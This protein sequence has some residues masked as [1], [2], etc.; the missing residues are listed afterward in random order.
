MTGN[1]FRCGYVQNHETCSEE[2]SNTYFS[3]A[4]C[5]EHRAILARNLSDLK[6]STARQSANHHELSDFPG[7]CYFA[8]MPDASVKIG[9]S[10][11][12]ELLG[13]RFKNISK[14]AGSHVIPL[15]VIRGGF[16]AEA[17]MHHRFQEDRIWEESERFRYTPAMAEF[18]GGLQPDELVHI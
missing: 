18:L 16:V 12:P 10:N 11:T 3:L 13:K 4:V 17:V 6:G 5:E 14:D 1:T 9:Y 2:T 8:L 7:Y 15:A